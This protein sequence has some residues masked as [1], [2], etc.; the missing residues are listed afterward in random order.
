[1]SIRIGSSCALSVPMAIGKVCETR[2]LSDHTD[3]QEVSKHCIDNK[4]YLIVTPCV[5]NGNNQSAIPTDDYWLKIINDACKYLR[6][7]GGNKYNCRLSLVNEP[8]KWL[9]KEH[10]AHLINIAYP[11]IKGYGF[12]VGAGNEEFIM[13]Q[14]H[15]NMYQYIL[16]NAKFDILDI[17]I[18]GSCDT[19]ERTRQWTDEALSWSKYWN[20][21]LDCTEA[22]YENIATSRGW[23]LIQSQLYHAE[24]IGC[25]N[26][27]NVFNNLDVKAF[28]ILSKPDVLAKWSE[29]SFKV[30]GVI[31]SNYWAHW[32]ILMDTKHPVPNI[33]EIIEELDDM[34]LSVLKL[35]SKSNQVLWLQEILELEYGFENEGSFDGVYGSKT[36]TQVAAYQKANNLTVDGLVGKFTMVDLINKSTNPKAWMNRL[37]IYMAYE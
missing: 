12:L 18:Q 20:K 15:G 16:D 30:N 1:M 10:Y 6:S 29:I 8:M 19:P 23:E 25:Q 24:R 32:K 3:W 9:N 26:F 7:I 33:I 31:R 4:I 36:F 28:P 2:I 27:C 35:G 17:H 22:F 21:P 13:A 11:I 14:A 34:K 5:N 37:E